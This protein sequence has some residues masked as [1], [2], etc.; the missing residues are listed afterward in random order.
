MERRYRYKLVP[1][2]IA[3]VLR[4]IML[5]SSNQRAQVAFHRRSPGGGPQVSADVM[6]PE[7]QWSEALMTG[8]ARLRGTCR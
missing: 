8:T 2:V 7:V 4:C 6:V 1:G 5:A 3:G